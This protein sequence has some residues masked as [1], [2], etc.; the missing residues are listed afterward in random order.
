MKSTTKWLTLAMTAAAGMMFPLPAAA[1]SWVEFRTC[2]QTR[3]EVLIEGTSTLHAWTVRGRVIEGSVRVE[4]NFLL[5]A[6]ANALPEGWP[7]SGIGLPVEGQLAIPGRSLRSFKDGRPYS[8]KMDEIMYEKL[9]VSV[10][11][12]I[13]YALKRLE[14]GLEASGE[15]GKM[16]LVAEGELS[17]A[18]EV[19]AFSMPVELSRLDERRLR[20]SGK[21][22]LTMTAFKVDPPRAMAGAIR[23]G[24]EISIRVTWFVVREE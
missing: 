9:Q 7:E 20:F 10:Y 16:A 21:A 3:S 19:L 13:T 18:G 4:E 5:K 14:R 11:P 22:D 1:G 12:E 24:D 23:T 6:G 15:A 8:E 2:P 17:V